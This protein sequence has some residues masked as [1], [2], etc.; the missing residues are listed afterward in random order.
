MKN[1]LNNTAA[2]LLALLI[3]AGAVPDKLFAELSERAGI[4]ASA[5][6]EIITGSC[7]DDT[8]WALGPSTGTQT[9]SGT[10][11]VTS[12]T[13]S[14]FIIEITHVIIEDGITSICSRAFLQ[15]WNLKTVEIGSTVESIGD[16]AFVHCRKMESVKIGSGVDSISATAFEGCMALQS[17]VIP[18]NVTSIDKSA[19]KSIDDNAIMVYNEAEN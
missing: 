12:D 19:F 5:A 4:T 13:W 6:D 1:F 14:D 18:D 2:G 16:S 3:V 9:I 8:T 10:G 17:V 15:Y 11:E 7:G